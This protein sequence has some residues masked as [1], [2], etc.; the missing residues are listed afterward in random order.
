MDSIDRPTLS[1]SGDTT[2]TPAVRPVPLAAPPA[3][4]LPPVRDF[5][6]RTFA[7]GR[8]SIAPALPALAFLYFYRF[9][10][11][12]YM[13]TTGNVTSPMGYPDYQLRAVTWI[14]AATAYLP[15]LVLIYTP[16]LPFQDALYRGERRSFV[17]SVKQ[18][19]EVLLP[20]GISSLFQLL[21]V[22]IPATLIIV[23]AAAATMAM[24]AIPV[25][26]RSLL[27]LLAM[28]PAGMWV[29]FSLF[30]LVF[31]T[32]LLVL[33]G[34]GP[35]ESIRGSF[36]LVR[37]NFGG[38]L[39]RF[40]VAIAL[41]TLVMIF[42]SFPSAMLSVLA[43][44][45][46]GKLMGVDVARLVWDSAVETLAFPFTVAAMIVL[47][48]A[49]VPARGAAASLAAEAAPAAGETAPAAPTSPYSFE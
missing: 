4:V 22:V 19:L 38:L 30:L 26:A 29:A 2:T 21:L 15:L 5:L 14:V 3:P 47:Y 9:G 42:L 31:A 36:S 7:L 46:K 32:P 35:L 43:S 16:F 11:G 44:V 27:V 13:V 10:M 23:A 18:V 39:W 20:Y 8:R 17:D 25:Q 33:E 45:T 40:L 48:R 49:L 37:Q 41:L 24:G 34:R 6:L 12:V 1:P 28:I